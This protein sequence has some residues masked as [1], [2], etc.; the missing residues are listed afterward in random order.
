MHHWRACPVNLHPGLASP[1]TEQHALLHANWFIN[2]VAL[3]VALSLLLP[4]CHLKA[5]RGLGS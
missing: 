3:L 2:P 4:G 1:A 5:H